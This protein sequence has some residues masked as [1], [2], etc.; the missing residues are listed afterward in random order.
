MI[1]SKDIDISSLIRDIEVSNILDKTKEKLYEVIKA[2]FNSS[3]QRIYLTKTEE[4]EEYIKIVSSQ[5]Q[6][7]EYH[8]C[9]EKR[10]I[11]SLTG[12]T[13]IRV[14]KILTIYEIASIVEDSLDIINREIA[15]SNYH[16]KYI[17]TT[18]FAAPKEVDPAF[19]EIE[20]AKR[21]ISDM[22]IPSHKK[23]RA[24]D[25]LDKIATK[26][27]IYG[28]KNPDYEEYVAVRDNTITLVS[29][30]IDP[31]TGINGPRKYKTLYGKALVEYFDTNSKTIDQEI[32]STKRR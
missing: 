29:T 18:G 7:N 23:Q 2:I 30:I 10:I 19:T 11:N 32:R 31:S 27:K 22:N 21:Q 26:R 1:K 8:F 20:K 28:I 24:L 15:N 13:E 6:E 16:K 9:L 3:N 14:P 4:A 17:E 5:E 12:G 25:A